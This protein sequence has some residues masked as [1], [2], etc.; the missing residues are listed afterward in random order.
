VPPGGKHVLIVDPPK[1]KPWLIASKEI[2]IEPG[3]DNA[4]VDIQVFRG[5]WLEGKVTDAKMGEPI[6]GRVD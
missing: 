5:I 1:S 3:Q 4:K 2:S 6:K